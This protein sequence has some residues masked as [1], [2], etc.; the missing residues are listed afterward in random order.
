MQ[1][2]ADYCYSLIA[3]QSLKINS[4]LRSSQS[5]RGSPWSKLNVYMSIVLKQ[6]PCKTPKLNLPRI[7]GRH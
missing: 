7:I 6:R 5:M 3:G 4:H 2:I 1:D